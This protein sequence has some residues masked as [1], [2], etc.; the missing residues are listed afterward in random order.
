MIDPEDAIEVHDTLIARFGGSY[1]VRDQ[2]RLKAALDRAFATF[3]G[4]ELHPDPSDKAAALLE[5]FLTDHPFLDGNKRTGY[6]L[7]RLI[8]QERGLDIQAPQKDKY[9]FVMSVAQGER[10]LDGIKR[11]IEDRSVA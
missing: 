11:W 7:M 10:R 4:E 5:A 8:L 9:E 1:G 3:D 6:V 2:K